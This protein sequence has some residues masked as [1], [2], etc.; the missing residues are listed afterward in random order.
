MSGGRPRLGGGGASLEDCVEDG[1]VF[2]LVTPDVIARVE[3][4]WIEGL[5]LISV[6][7]PTLVNRLFFH[8]SREHS[9]HRVV[10]SLLPV[11]SGELTGESRGEL[12]FSII[13]KLNVLIFQ[14]LYGQF[15]A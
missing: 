9:I 7:I 12:L 1:F 2:C 5:M 8:D 15:K 14:F 11:E 4:L 6:F 10:Q 3:S 13:N